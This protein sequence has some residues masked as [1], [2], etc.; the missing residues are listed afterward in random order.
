MENTSVVY[1]FIAAIV[2]NVISV[3]AF[4]LL[5]RKFVWDVKKRKTDEQQLIVERVEKEHDKDKETGIKIKESI[6]AHSEECQKLQRYGI[7]ERINKENQ[8]QKQLDEQSI[9]QKKTNEKLE[10]TNE[11]LEK[12]SK[13]IV[14][15]TEK[16]N[17]LTA[18]I[19]KLENKK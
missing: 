2:T 13:D 16:I 12:L 18:I 10:K 7:K 4:I 11:K 5:L 15:L 9:E 1:G 8:M 3:V 19:V 6:E 17:A 14:M